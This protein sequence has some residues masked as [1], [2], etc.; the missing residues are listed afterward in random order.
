MRNILLYKILQQPIQGRHMGCTRG[1]SRFLALQL[2]AQDS[3]T[4]VSRSAENGVEGVW[5]AT[6]T[7]RVNTDTTCA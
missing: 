5:Q 7:G 1:A 6:D 4:T 2:G 3:D